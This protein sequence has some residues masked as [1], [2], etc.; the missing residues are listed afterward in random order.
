M[1][2]DADSVAI[3]E[4][5]A[6]YDACMDY[7]PECKDRGRKGKIYK[8]DPER[9]KEIFEVLTIPAR[10]EVYDK[11]EMFITRKNARKAQT[12]GQR[13]MSAFGEVSSY[14]IF[15]FM[16]VMLVEQ[17]QQ[18]AK[19]MTIGLLIAFTYV[20]VQLK[21][22]K[23]VNA[24]ENVVIQIVNHL[25][26]LNRY[27]Y[28]EIAFLLKNTLFPSLFNMTLNISRIIDVEPILEFKRRILDAQKKLTS[29]F[30]PLEMIMKKRENDEEFRAKKEKEDEEE[31]KARKELEA[32]KKAADAKRRGEI[33][34]QAVAAGE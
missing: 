13:Y 19:Q 25:P 7:E 20:T 24:D 6:Q 26:F 33:E 31:E 9:V 17:H 22:P 16:T 34:L 27:C 3:A 2:R 30:L 23:E 15:I 8:L 12:E 1:T 5:K 4:A 32:Q 29:S 28:F 14:S 11:T 21:M 18:F 10:R